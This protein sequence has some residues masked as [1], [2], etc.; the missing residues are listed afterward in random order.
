MERKEPMGRGDHQPI[1]TA[2]IASNFLPADQERLALF[3]YF[4]CASCHGDMPLHM[5]ICIKVHNNTFQAATFSMSLSQYME[6]MALQR[7]ALHL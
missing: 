2:I 5:Q 1:S 3:N 6:I 4:S 7:R